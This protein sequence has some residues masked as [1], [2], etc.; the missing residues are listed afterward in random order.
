MAVDS[1]RSKGYRIIFAPAEADSSQ[2]VGV[3]LAGDL[4]PTD[5]FTARISADLLI[6]DG[7][8]LETYLSMESLSKGL[9]DADW[10]L[11]DPMPIFDDFGEPSMVRATITAVD[12][13]VAGGFLAIWAD[14]GIGVS[15]SIRLKPEDLKPNN[16]NPTKFA[17]C[18]SQAHVIQSEAWFVSKGRNINQ[19]MLYPVNYRFNYG[20]PFSP[21][22]FTNAPDL[23]TFAQRLANGECLE[24]PGAVWFK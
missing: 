23:A 6:S 13:G 1:L 12:D 22:M 2:R 9:S 19:A 5:D 8:I 7:N 10:K 24:T 21:A 17:I 15:Y 11:F 14:E 4:L 18:V 16:G 20:Q 3:I